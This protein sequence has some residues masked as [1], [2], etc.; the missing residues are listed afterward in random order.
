MGKVVGKTLFQDEPEEPQKPQKKLTTKRLFG[1]KPEEGSKRQR[2]SSSTAPPPRVLFGD[3]GEETIRTG[4]GSAFDAGS[5]DEGALPKEATLNLDWSA[6]KLFS[7]AT[8]LQK[9]VTESKVQRQKRPY[10]NTK[11][12]EQAANTFKHEVTPFKDSALQPGRL[13]ALR[14]KKQC[15]W[16]S[17]FKLKWFALTPSRFVFIYVCPTCSQFLCK[18]SLIIAKVDWRIASSSSMS[19][20]VGASLKHFGIWP[21]VSRIPLSL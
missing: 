7:H 3:E 17:F 18:A 8:F 14:E 19:M 13:E 21:N 9:S 16:T 2:S 6:M 1:N 10:D 15:K 12:A 5:D 11:R 4:P 20:S